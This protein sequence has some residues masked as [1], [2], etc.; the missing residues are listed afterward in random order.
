MRW[1]W[2]SATGDWR[3]SIRWSGGGAAAGAGLRGADRA[4][5]LPAAEPVQ[6][7]AAGGLAR[8]GRPGAGG[9][10][11]RPVVVPPL[12]R[13]GVGRGGAGPLHLVAL[14]RPAAAAGAGR[15]LVRPGE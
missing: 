2:A 3:R 9:G 7:G 13:A 5:V 12:R 6:S 15:R 10:T 1:L 8:A 4:G 11:G 14:P